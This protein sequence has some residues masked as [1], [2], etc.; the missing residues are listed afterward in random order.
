[1]PLVFLDIKIKEI[2]QVAKRSAHFVKAGL[3]V[4]IDDRGLWGN[5]NTET[6]LIT[7]SLD[8]RYIC[9]M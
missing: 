5:E 1:M 2:F 3:F 6:I 4:V 7:K 9:K 8:D